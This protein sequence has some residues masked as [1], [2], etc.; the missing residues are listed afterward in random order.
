MNINLT[1]IAQA[2]TFAIFIWFTARFI[3]PPLMSAVER[4][5]KTIADGLAAAEQGNRSLKDAEVRVQTIEREARA[6][7]QAIMADTEKRAAA[8]IE[9]AKV[10]AKTEGGRLLA[11]AKAEVGQ[12][13]ER[14]KST[15]REQVANLA[16]MG[17]EQILKR[18][19][20]SS[21]HAEMLSRLKAQ[22]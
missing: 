12:E 10:Q 7:A 15:L 13:I 20:N 16:V 19:V 8:L 11:A 4:R 1:L 21:A 14:A 22:L 2:I 5:Q 18:E 6:K 9:E 17:A 3:W